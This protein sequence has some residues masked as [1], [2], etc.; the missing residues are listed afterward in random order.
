[1]NRDETAEGVVPVVI[2]AVINGVILV[3][4]SIIMACMLYIN[5][6]Y[7]REIAQKQIYITELEKEIKQYEPLILKIKKD[8]E[9]TEKIYKEIEKL[10]KE[11]HK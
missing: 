1:M 10:K 2:T 6:I 9:Q 5:G 11:K 8:K 4:V 7:D 3:L